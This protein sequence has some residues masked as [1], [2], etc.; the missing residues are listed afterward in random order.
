MWLCDYTPL[1]GGG[2]EGDD[3]PP[4]DG[5]VEEEVDGNGNGSAAAASP[6]TEEEQVVGASI[7]IYIRVYNYSIFSNNNRF[8]YSLKYVPQG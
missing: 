1:G 2:A 5:M 3:A 6:E 8:V 7:F 4:G